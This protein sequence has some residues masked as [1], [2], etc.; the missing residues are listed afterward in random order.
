MSV[1]R[2]ALGKR[3]SFY[4]LKFSMTQEKLAD[5]TNCSREYIAYLENGVKT[6]SL[7]ILVDL[8]N[9]LHI[10]VDALLVDSLDYSLSSSDSDLHR[11]LLDCNETEQEIIIPISF[12]PLCGI[13]SR[14]HLA[15]FAH[16]P[17]VILQAFIHAVPMADHLD[18]RKMSSSFGCSCQIE[19]VH[20][21]SPSVPVL[22]QWLPH[23]PP[24]TPNAAVRRLPVDSRA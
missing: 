20:I 7:P 1:N 2:I 13:P 22:L 23:H 18:Q 12:H 5:L 19:S 3:I 14:S 15:N 17:I 10:S 21:L 24:G 16:H 4:R 11:L 9:A 6:P 8:A